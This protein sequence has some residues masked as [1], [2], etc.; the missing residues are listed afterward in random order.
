MEEIGRPR[1]SPATGV[2]LMLWDGIP[3]G[4]LGLTG[5]IL[6]D[7]P[8]DTCR[9]VFSLGKDKGREKMQ[10]GISLAEMC[11]TR[12]KFGDDSPE[13]KKKKVRKLTLHKLNPKLP[14]SRCNS[15]SSPVC[16]IKRILLFPHTLLLP[17]VF[18]FWWTAPPFLSHNLDLC[19]VL[20][21]QNRSPFSAFHL[22]NQLQIHPLK[23]A[24]QMEFPLS[25]SPSQWVRY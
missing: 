19:W 25:V 10:T 12:A 24:L 8:Q 9:K 13:K 3:V 1:L 2:L 4:A 15:L 7:F 17:H 5:C 20:Q 21:R 18:C 23:L 14:P 6:V 16:P 22:R 11:P